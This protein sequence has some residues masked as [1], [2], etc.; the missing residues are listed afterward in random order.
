LPVETRKKRKSRGGGKSERGRMKSSK[1]QRVR[2]GKD[3]KQ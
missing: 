3:E 2:E 1:G